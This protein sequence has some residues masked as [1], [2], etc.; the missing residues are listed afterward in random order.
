MTH[1]KFVLELWEES[2]KDEHC[3]FIKNNE[4]DCRCNKIHDQETAKMVCDHFSLQLWCLTKDHKNCVFF[5]SPILQD[6]NS[7]V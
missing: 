5:D 1:R 4:G 3:P 7:M 6:A 2:T